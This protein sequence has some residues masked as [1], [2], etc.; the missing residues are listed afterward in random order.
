M[1][2]RGLPTV[3]R[4]NALDL[5]ATASGGNAATYTYDATG[6]KLRS[7]VGNITTDYINGIEW[8]GNVLNVLHMEEGA[9]IR[10]LLMI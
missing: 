4:V 2:R 3:S 10:R 8:A 9:L 6:R 1:T 7:V 5:P